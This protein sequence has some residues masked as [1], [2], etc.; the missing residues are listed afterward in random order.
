[1]KVDK[2]P[3]LVLLI[4]VA[5]AAGQFARHYPELPE[6]IA[7]HFGSDGRANG[8]SD[9]DAF[10]LT[11]GAVEAIIVLTALALAFLGDRIPTSS[12]NLPNRDY[13]LAPERRRETLRFAWTRVAWLEAATLAFL[14]AVAE[15]IF[16]ANRTAGPPTLTS[17]FFVVLAAFVVAILWQSV[18][19]MLRFRTPKE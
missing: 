9:K 3:L 4:L 16:R 2:T 12:V 8:W 13:W 19:M 17:D 11:Y 15:I 18:S 6:T 5:V 7:V 1:M 14:I 10:V